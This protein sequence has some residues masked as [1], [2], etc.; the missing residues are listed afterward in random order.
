MN[1]SRKAPSSTPEP[2]K[3]PRPSKEE[4]EQS[5]REMAEWMESK[6]K[7]WIAAGRPEVELEDEDDHPL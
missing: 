4:I 1:T 2:P 5:G 7:A 3:P 6:H